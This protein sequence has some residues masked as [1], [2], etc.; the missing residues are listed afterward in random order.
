MLPGNAITSA[1]YV[2]VKM[3]Q[4]MVHNHSKTVNLAILSSPLA[5]PKI[6]SYYGKNR[7]VDFEW[8]KVE[9]GS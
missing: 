7:G 5:F 3:F 2:L 1:N 6:S 4:N 8:E 9:K